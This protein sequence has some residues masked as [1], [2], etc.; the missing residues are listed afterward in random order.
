[1]CYRWQYERG[2]FNTAKPLATLALNLFQKQ[3]DQNSIERY[4]QLSLIHDVLGCVANGTNQPISSMTH[5]KE[6]LAL[7]TAISEQRG[8]PDELLA[9]AHNQYG[10]SMMACGR[11]DEGREL[12]AEALQIWH[13]LPL[14]QPGDDNTLTKPRYKPGD[15]SMEYANLGIAH[16]LRGEVDEASN[17]LEEGLNE[18]IKGFGKDDHE[19]FR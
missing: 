5:N 18:R 16:W 2:N 3:G 4:H 1:M 15:A 14:Y 9:Y 11:Y 6:F 12:F 17:I 13:R 8:E 7:R 10:C 19:S